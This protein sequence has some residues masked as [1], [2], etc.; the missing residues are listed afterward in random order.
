MSDIK[1]QLNSKKGKR[2]NDAGLGADR[3]NDTRWKCQ[4]TLIRNTELQT[5]EPVLGL[6]WRNQE[7]AAL[8]AHDSGSQHNKSMQPTKKED[9]NH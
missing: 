8:Y 2:N 5:K 3:E 7:F 6:I 1:T 4:Y 9:D